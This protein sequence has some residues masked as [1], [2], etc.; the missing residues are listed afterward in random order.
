M[1]DYQI[2]AINPGSTSTKISVFNGDEAVFVR[3]VK[4][5][6]SHDRE[7]THDDKVSEIKNLI[8]REL[9]TIGGFDI[10]RIDAF[11]G[12]GGGVVHCA[13]GTYEINEIMINDS[14]ENPIIH[15][16]KF[17]PQ[18]AYEFARAH[19]KKAYMV[20]SPHSDEFDEVSRVCGLAGIERVSSVHALNQKEVAYRAAAELG[21]KYE[22]LNFVVAHLGGGFSITAHKRGKMIDSTDN[23]NGEGPMSINRCGTIAVKS[24]VDLCFSG[25]HTKESMYELIM[26]KSGLLGHLGASDGMA[27]EKMVKEGDKHAKTVFDAMLQ[28]IAKSIGAMAAV[29]DGD[30]Q[31]VILT[32]G[33]AKDPYLVDTLTRKAKFIAPVL[34]Y[35]GEFEMEAL[36]NG[37]LRVLRKQEECIAYT[38]IP[39]WTGFEWDKKQVQN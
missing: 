7:Q 33:L 18:I 11:V 20:N 34:V 22:D 25:T 27:I 9:S 38:G 3:N 8:L 23:I 17:A 19:G 26:T 30:V 12:R 4:H 36:T 31:A 2:L 1:N 37:V 24:I 16:S 10:A 35:P 28:Q 14:R 29:L 13:P 5:G 6:A 21:G 15:P 32:G 39:A